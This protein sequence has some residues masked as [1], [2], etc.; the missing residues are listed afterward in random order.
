LAIVESQGKGPDGKYYPGL[1][2]SSRRA[3]NYFGIKKGVNWTGQ[4]INLPTPGDADKISTFRK[5]ASIED[6]FEDF[7]RFLSV[8]PRYK[9]AGIFDAPD[10]ITQMQLIAKA[11]YAEN[12]NY[13]SL[14]TNV[15]NSVNNT[16][17]QVKDIVKKP[18]AI[19]LFVALGAFL[20]YSLNTQK[21]AAKIY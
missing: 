14:L 11:G 19:I 2:A 10:F 6:S 4:T 3:N 1:N 21:N 20:L 17:K 12:P 8:N 5:Y 15:A 7:G 18:P 9:K 16:I 13:A